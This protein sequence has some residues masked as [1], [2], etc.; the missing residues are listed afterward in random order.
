MSCTKKKTGS[1]TYYFAKNMFS[2]IVYP[3]KVK[4]VHGELRVAMRSISSRGAK[5]Q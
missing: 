2:D 5:K 4:Y 1:C 3:Q